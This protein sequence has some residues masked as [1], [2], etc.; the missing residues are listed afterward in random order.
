VRL[1]N[2]NREEQIALQDAQS[3]VRIIKRDKV[4]PRETP[5]G[6]NGDSD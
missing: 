2:G 3:I 6:E 5:P 4:E 1:A